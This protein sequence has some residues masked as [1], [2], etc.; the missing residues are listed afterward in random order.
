F[1]PDAWHFSTVIDGN[2]LWGNPKQNG[3]GGLWYPPAVDSQGRVFLVVA[4][5]AAPCRTRPPIRTPRAGPARTST[6]TRWSR[7][8]ATPARCS[9]TS[10]VTSHD[11]RDYDFEASPI[12]STQD[13]D[14]A[15]TEIAIGAGKSG[16]VVAFRADNG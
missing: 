3:G 9:C 6:P 2:K 5:P 11:V 4:N 7:S 14:G 10:R 8:T 16:K 15:Q 12:V 13:I 1:D